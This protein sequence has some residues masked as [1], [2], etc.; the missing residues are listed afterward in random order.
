MSDEHKPAGAP[1]SQ[2]KSVLPEDVKFDPAR[3]CEDCGVQGAYDLNGAH[4]CEA[5]V[6]DSLR[7]LKS[8]GQSRTR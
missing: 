3:V 1:G 6:E 8:P 2:A 5:C 4:L 7:G